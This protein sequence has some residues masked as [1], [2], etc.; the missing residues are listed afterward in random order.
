MMFDPDFDEKVR[1]IYVQQERVYFAAHRA[2]VAGNEVLREEL[3]DQLVELDFEQRALLRNA[4][5]KFTSLCKIDQKASDDDKVAQLLQAFSIGAKLVGVWDDAMG[6]PAISA[7]F[8]RKLYKINQVLDTIGFGRAGALGVFL[9][10]KDPNVQ[11]AAA[12]RLQ[13]YFPERCVRV[14]KKL[15]I[16]DGGN[17]GRYA[18]R[19]LPAH[20]LRCSLPAA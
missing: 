8:E 5:A 2:K 6:K 17:A 11:V 14:L 9:D 20:C 12:V 10:D 7:R 13:E 19:F 15:G 1:H 4:S 3:R 18:R 16:E